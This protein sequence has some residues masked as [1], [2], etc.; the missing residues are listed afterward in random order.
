MWNKEVEAR[1]SEKYVVV[2]EL[3]YCLAW[4]SSLL[5]YFFFFVFP[6]IPEVSGKET[7]PP[8]RHHIAVM[9][10]WNSPVRK[11]YLVTITVVPKR[12][13]ASKFEG[14]LSSLA[15]TIPLAL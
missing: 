4:L 7:E 8:I 2:L 6:K 13:L 9:R 11:V 10:R 5:S 14:F 12:H 1:F 15:Y 3:V